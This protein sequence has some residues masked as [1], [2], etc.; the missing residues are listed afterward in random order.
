MKITNFMICDDLRFEQN[1]K[2]SLMGLYEDVIYFN[3][4]SSSRGKWPK[5]FSFAILLR[6][7]I[8]DKDVEAG[9]EAIVI[10]LNISNTEQEIA[11]FNF[12]PEHLQER[13]NISLMPKIN[14]YPIPSE[15]NLT[16]KVGL[17][18]K[19]GKEVDSLETSTI[20]IIESVTDNL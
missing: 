20:K 2:I 17:L 10:T 16:I 15:G 7:Q 14:N 6:M 18:D 5:P 8:E 13:K 9:M 19:N 11:K 3:V 12:R 1:N 4:N